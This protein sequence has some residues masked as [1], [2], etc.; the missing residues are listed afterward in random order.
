MGLINLN[1]VSHDQVLKPQIE[2]KTL[3]SIPKTLNSHV[4]NA[5]KLQNPKLCVYNL[6]LKLEIAWQNLKN[7]KWKTTHLNLKHNPQNY[8]IMCCTPKPQN[9]KSR[10]QILTLRLHNKT[11]T[12]K[13]IV[14]Y[15]NPKTP[16]HAPNLNP[17]TLNHVLKP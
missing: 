17:K 2:F 12:V 8:K 11:L 16:N 13:V 1:H 14:A 6:T 4:I 3:T 7:Q 5:P 9:P 15:S 10:T